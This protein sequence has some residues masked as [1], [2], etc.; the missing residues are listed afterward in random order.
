MIPTFGLTMRSSPKVRGREALGWGI[1]LKR[2]EDAKD[3]LFHYGPKTAKF[4]E[5]TGSAKA[6][7]EAGT[8][9]FKYVG[10]HVFEKTYCESKPS[11][12]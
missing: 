5:L 7:L 3:A 6:E 12:H 4:D 2:H 9:L 1:E 10:N 8:Q 11:K